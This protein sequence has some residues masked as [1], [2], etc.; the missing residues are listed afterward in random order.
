MR[1]RDGQ[2]RE[3]QHSEGQ[4]YSL[5]DRADTREVLSMI[6][7]LAIGW[8]TSGAVATPRPSLGWSLWWI[9]KTLRIVWR[10]FSDR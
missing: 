8:T 1:Q 2:E 3:T 9:S 5:M 6:Y 7:G 10:V 4:A